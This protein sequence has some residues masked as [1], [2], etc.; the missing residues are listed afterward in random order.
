MN[1]RKKLLIGVVA[2]TLTNA[3]FAAKK[4][5]DA[6]P[7]MDTA[8]K[9]DAA[10][11]K[12]MELG[13]P[14][15]NHKV[16]DAYVGTWNCTLRGWMKPGDKP[17]ESK[18]V[19]ENTWAYGGRFLKQEFKGDWAGQPFSGSGIIGYDNVR[20]E[21]QSIWYDSMSTGIMQ[22]T[23]SYDP[24]TKTLAVSGTFGCPMT[25]EK[26]FW[27]R[28]DMKSVDADNFTYT[29]YAKDPSGKE[30]KSMEILYTRVK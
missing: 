17:M 10:M 5:T 24:A 27:I 25:G 26:N 6:A 23:G 20:G 1:T 13:L 16:L 28:S 18:G 22:M 19:S 9:M 7:K 12:A 8:P 21:Y 29:S 15:A 3:S 11:Q 14:N 2:F 4:A 30:F